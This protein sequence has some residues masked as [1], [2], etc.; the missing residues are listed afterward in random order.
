MKPINKRIENKFPKI[1]AEPRA[2]ETIFHKI[3]KVR[4]ADMLHLSAAKRA[5]N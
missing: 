2:P 1:L 3:K 5:I 4:S